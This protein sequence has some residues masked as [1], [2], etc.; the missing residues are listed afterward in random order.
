[1]LTQRFSAAGVDR[2]RIRFDTNLSYDKTTIALDNFSNNDFVSLSD[3]ILSGATP[4]TL[5]GR[6]FPAQQNDQLL[7]QLGLEKSIAATEFEFIE[8][9]V[10]LAQ[11]GVKKSPLRALKKHQKNLTDISSFAKTVRNILVD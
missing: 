10:K 11:K 4:I 5:K 1:L 3:A 9:A 8:H 6:L 7:K 2:S